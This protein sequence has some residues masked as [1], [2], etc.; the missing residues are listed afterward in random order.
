[1][2]DLAGLE[3][4]TTCV[5]SEVP[6]L[7]TT[8]GKGLAGKRRQGL[9]PKGLSYVAGLT[10]CPVR[11]EHTTSVPCGAVLLPMQSLPSPPPKWLLPR[12][13]GEIRDAAP[14]FRI[15][16]HVLYQLSYR[17]TLPRPGRTR[18]CDTVVPSE[19]TDLFT[20]GAAKGLPGKGREWDGR[21]RRRVSSTR[22][23]RRGAPRGERLHDTHYPPGAT[24]KMEQSG[25][26]YPS[27][28]PPANLYQGNMSRRPFSRSNPPLHH[29]KFYETPHVS[30][31]ETP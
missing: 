25:A 18:T 19:V 26:K 9:S 24:A 3:P 6:G 29:L 8:G 21:A 13:T 23:S 12:G 11:L 15:L 2:M 31:V 14:S 30:G 28:S 10:T 20:T 22:S 17:D 7:F 27:S 16:R 5:A 4:A 1:M